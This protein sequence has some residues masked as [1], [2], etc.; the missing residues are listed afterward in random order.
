MSAATV[1]V[2][3]V[4]LMA[5]HEDTGT[6][7]WCAP[8]VYMLCPECDDVARPRRRPDCWRCGGAGRL[9][10]PDPETYDGP[11]GLIVVHDPEDDA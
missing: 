6:R 8:R 4:D 7:C 2:L 5:A 3:P 9:L 11:Y 10:C 1:H